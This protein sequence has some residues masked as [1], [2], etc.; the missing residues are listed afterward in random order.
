M[1]DLLGHLL[2]RAAKEHA[3]DVLSLL[4][5]LVS[6]LGYLVLPL[7]GTE[8][9]AQRRLRRVEERPTNVACSIVTKLCLAAGPAAD[10]RWVSAFEPR[11]LLGDKAHFAVELCFGGPASHPVAPRGLGL[12]II[13]CL[14]RRR[15]M[16]LTRWLEELLFEQCLMIREHTLVHMK[17]HA[18]KFQGAISLWTFDKRVWLV[19]HGVVPCIGRVLPTFQRG[20]FHRV[21]SIKNLNL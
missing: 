1:L 5:S 20:L 4:E 18:V 3:V 10:S 11:T 14:G 8:V 6:G 16:K 17:G 21:I 15:D 2:V 7:G 9:A 13:T 12:A 19:R